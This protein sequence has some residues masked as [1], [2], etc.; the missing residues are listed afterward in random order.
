MVCFQLWLLYIVPYQVIYLLSK[1]RFYLKRADFKN[2]LWAKENFY[3]STS[4]VTP[5]KLI[6][7]IHGCQLAC[8]LLMEFLMG[9]WKI[10]KVIEGI[11]DAQPAV[12]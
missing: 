12:H 6:T 9:Y 1:E 4:E 7:C 8:L 2:D 5:L 3:M 11:K 10:S